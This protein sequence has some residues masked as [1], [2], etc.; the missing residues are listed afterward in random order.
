MSVVVV[1]E[2]VVVPGKLLRRQNAG[3]ELSASGRWESGCRIPEQS[4]LPGSAVG[5]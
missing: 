3:V 4:H 1:P 2:K 5:K